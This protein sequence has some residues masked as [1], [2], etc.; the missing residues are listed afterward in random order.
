MLRNVR[1]VNFFTSSNREQVPRPIIACFPASNPSFLLF[2]YFRKKGD[3]SGA[4]TGKAFPLQIPYPKLDHNNIV[5]IFCL[6]FSCIYFIWSMSM[7]FSLMLILDKRQLSNITFKHIIRYSIQCPANKY[8]WYCGQ[9]KAST[10]PW[11]EKCNYNRLS[12]FF[13]KM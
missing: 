3:K 1:N 12:G 11:L 7:I 6:L 2:S 10:N 13:T 9:P 4:Y 8:W 5:I